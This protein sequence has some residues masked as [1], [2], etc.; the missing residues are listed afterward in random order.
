MSQPL[1][2]GVKFQDLRQDEAFL[3]APVS[4]QVQYLQQSY[5]PEHD[6]DFSKAPKKEQLQYINEVVLPELH[7][8]NQPGIPLALPEQ[9]PHQPPEWIPGLEHAALTVATPLASVL[10]GASLGY[11]DQPEE[12]LIEKTREVEERLPEDYNRFLYGQ[13]VDSQTSGFLRGAGDMVGGLKTLGGMEH[14]GQQALG[15][16]AKTAAPWITPMAEAAGVFNP[17]M[18][19]AAKVISFL[20]GSTLKARALRDSLNFG[21]YEGLKNQPN[22][23]RL[24]SA[25]FGV[26][27]GAAFG[28]A[29]KVLKG[30]AKFVEGMAR[31]EEIATGLNAIKPLELPQTA[32]KK[33]ALKVFEELTGVVRDVQEGRIDPNLVDA[34]DW[35]KLVTHMDD[36]GKAIGDNKLPT[37]INEALRPAR[38]IQGKAKIRAMKQGRGLETPRPELEI[39]EA[40]KN[41]T[42]EPAANTV[43]S[44]SE[45]NNAGGITVKPPKISGK[46]EDMIKQL[47]D[48]AGLDEE[49]LLKKK[50]KELTEAQKE[51]RGHIKTVR[52]SEPINEELG[53]YKQRPVDESRQLLHG[54]VKDSIPEEHQG[55]AS[56]INEAIEKDKAVRV[57]YKAEITGRSDKVAKVTKTGNIKIEPTTFTPTHFS[58]TKNGKVMAQGYNDRGHFVS[59]HLAPSE[60]GSQIVKAGTV[61]DKAFKGEYPNRV[62]GQREFRAEDILSRGLRSEQGFVKTSEAIKTLEQASQNIEKVF[63]LIDSGKLS[64]EAN[65]SLKELMSTE[66]WTQKHLNK[67]TKT[68]RSKE[69]KKQVCNILGLT[70]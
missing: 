20:Q 25:A 38:A 36:F 24:Q 48:S 52:N 41:I 51:I 39:T 59:Y 49:T 42:N 12:Y 60:S 69:F 58:K 30:S 40:P 33:R 5:L 19:K 14:L 47:S 10:K 29:G 15:S 2:A 45:V 11:F 54:Q 53:I 63:S 50:P 66:K 27:G 34:D 23:E 56:K 32:A 6:A 62:Y 9:Q 37:K 16:L 13:P 55:I 4:E 70:H 21:L 46:T 43:E 68:L 57:E 22:E 61:T 28:V 64:P 31:P 17:Y 67:F 18:A 26:A 1:Q 65:T 3:H 35:A 44:K 8:N 7:Q